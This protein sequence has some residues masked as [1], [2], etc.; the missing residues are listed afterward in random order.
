MP[1]KVAGRLARRAQA[2][3]GVGNRQT[4]SKNK[5]HVVGNAGLRTVSGG[6]LH[7]KTRTMRCQTRM[8][9][10]AERGADLIDGRLV[11]GLD[12]RHVKIYHNDTYRCQDD[13]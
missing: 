7:T 10:L 8:R 12:G 11:Q 2:S 3:K 13:L 9:C 6:E 5:R 4:I 1:R